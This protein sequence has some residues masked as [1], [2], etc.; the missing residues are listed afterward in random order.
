MGGRETEEEN[1]TLDMYFFFRS[2]VLN[3]VC[4]EESNTSSAHHGIKPL[5]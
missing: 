3:G 4:Q 5:N 2:V 1:Y